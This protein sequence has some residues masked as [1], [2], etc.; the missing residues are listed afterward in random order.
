MKEISDLE[1]RQASLD[2][3]GLAV[4]D[5]LVQ[6]LKVLVPQGEDHPAR[7]VVLPPQPHGLLTAGLHLII[8]II[9]VM[10]TI[11]ITI[12]IKRFPA[13]GELGTC[14]TSLV[15]LHTK[16]YMWCRQS[17]QP[18]SNSHQTAGAD[19]KREHRLQEY[20]PM[21]LTAIVRTWMV[22]MKVVS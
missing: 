3:A 11:V 9:I 7:V 2:D 5:D 17:P 4:L 22:M 18:W 8:I 19:D 1:G 20:W 6:G 15:L 21:I 13:H 10:I 12:I 16:S 14:R